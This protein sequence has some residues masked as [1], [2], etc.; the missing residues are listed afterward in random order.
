M[1]ANNNEEDPMLNYKAFF[2][3]R[4]FDESDQISA[5]TIGDIHIV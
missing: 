1:E 2:L 5:V 3:L 4:N